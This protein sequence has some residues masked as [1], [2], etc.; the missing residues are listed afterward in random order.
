MIGSCEVEASPLS[1]VDPAASLLR[2]CSACKPGL[3]ALVDDVW[4]A[5]QSFVGG[6]TTTVLIASL[7]LRAQ[8]SGRSLL[9]SSRLPAAGLLRI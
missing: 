4:T 1:L 5:R 8:R 6:C 2:V 3:G 9:P 7:E